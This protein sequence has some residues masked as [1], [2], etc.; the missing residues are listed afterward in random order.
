MHA[1]AEHTEIQPVQPS[2]CPISY[3]H[4]MPHDVH[5]R[6]N[7]QFESRNPDHALKRRGK[8]RALIEW[9]R[10]HIFCVDKCLV[11]FGVCLYLQ[12]AAVSFVLMLPMM[13]WILSGFIFMIVA[14]M[15]TLFLRRMC[16]SLIYNK[17]IQIFHLKHILRNDGDTGQGHYADHRVNGPSE[18]R[19]DDTHSS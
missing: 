2:L 11:L 3:S 18:Q 13:V 1:M 17:F 10:N 12:V 9:I 5:Y 8:L 16:P 7:R 4:E 15:C 14:A 6:L 19:G